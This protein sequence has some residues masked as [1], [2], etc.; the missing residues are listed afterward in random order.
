MRTQYE[1]TFSQRSKPEMIC[2]V[3]LFSLLS[4]YSLW[5]RWPIVGEFVFVLENGKH[6]LMIRQKSDFEFTHEIEVMFCVKVFSI[7]SY[8]IFQVLHG[9]L[10]ASD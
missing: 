10:A 6:Q 7:A 5:C 4:P 9:C 2:K 3:E 1:H 8:E